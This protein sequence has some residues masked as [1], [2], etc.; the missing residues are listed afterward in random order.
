MKKASFLICYFVLLMGCSTKT[1]IGNRLDLCEQELDNSPR[2]TYNGLNG[3]LQETKDLSDEDQARL[4]LLTIKAKN[5]AYIPL[6]GSDTI[7]IKRAIVY[8]QKHRDNNKLMMGYYLLGSIYRDLGDAPRG[9]QAF[10]EVIGSADTTKQDCDYKLMARAEGQVSDLQMYQKAYAKAIK[11]SEEAEYYGWKA[12]DTSFALNSAF[13]TIG[14]KALHG[15]YNPL[16]H[17]A[18]RLIQQTLNCGETVIVCRKA[19]SLAWHYLQI[20]SVR[21]AEMMIGFF[22]SYG[23]K[24]YSMYYGTKGE[25]ALAHHQL[26]SA[27]MCFREELKVTDWNNRQTAYRG[28]KKVF[29]QRHLVDSAL[30]YASLQCEAVDSDYQQKVTEEM[31][32]ME[33]VYNYESEKERAHQA[34]LE[35]TKMKGVLVTVTLAAAIFV[36]AVLFLFREYRHRQRII[37]EQREKENLVLKAQL[38]EQRRK[39]AE[40]E[41]LCREAE[42]QAARLENDLMVAHEDLVQQKDEKARLLQQRDKLLYQHA[43]SEREREETMQRAKMLEQQITELTHDIEETKSFLKQKETELL[44]S[45]EKI[46]EM[47]SLMEV[48]REDEWLVKKLGDGIQQ[49]KSCLKNGKSVTEL[50]WAALEKHVRAIYPQFIPALHQQVLPLPE[51]ELHLA[52]LIKTGFTPIQIAKLMSLSPSGV[53]KAR[54]RLYEKVHDKTPDDPK[55]VDDWLMSL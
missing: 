51:R 55:E 4:A 36:I 9:V 37:R 33:Q 16:I 7:S 44:T 47:R 27:E 40:A 13:E 28:L 53:T 21:E 43:G 15:D 38:E 18:P 8:Y 11:S 5:L 31:I 35:K 41:S 34:E 14:L 45:Q 12:R 10:L 48:Y 25:L 29:D 23:G 1:P 2:E 42:T 20:G 19:V 24:P 3:L 46:E 52:L 49:M 22:D 32:R 30:K 26:D 17:R 54:K 39:R 6:E 50:E